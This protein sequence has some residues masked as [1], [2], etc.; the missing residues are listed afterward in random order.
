MRVK[1]HRIQGS[2]VWG[3]F[4]WN[5]INQDL[6]DLVALRSLNA[7]N[8]QMFQGENVEESI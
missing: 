2:L 6:T 3:P 7:E 5:Q 1:S 8:Q 4:L